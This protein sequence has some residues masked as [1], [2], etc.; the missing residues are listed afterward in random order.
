MNFTEQEY[1]DKI[2]ILRKH[3]EY[4]TDRLQIYVELLDWALI[5][6]PEDPVVL[7]VLDRLT[8][9]LQPNMP[10]EISQRAKDKLAKVI[11]DQS[12]DLDEVYRATGWKPEPMQAGKHY[13]DL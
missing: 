4:L 3:N 6:H 13:E 2:E 9:N 8:D 11:I 5:N 12:V 10:A 7:G 1:K